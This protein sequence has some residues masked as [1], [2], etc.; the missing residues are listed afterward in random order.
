MTSNEKECGGI[1][2]EKEW[3]RS[4]PKCNNEIVYSNQYRLAYAIRDKTWCH[5]CWRF[6]RKNSTISNF[7]KDCPKCGDKVYLKTKYSLQR[8][9]ETNAVCHSCADRGN[10]GRLQSKEEKERRAIK[11]RGQKRSIEIRKRISNSKRGKRNPRFNDHSFK[12]IEHRR[13]IR[14]GC[15]KT[16]QTRLKLVGKIVSPAFNPDACNAIDEYG[17]RHEYAFQHALNGGEYYIEELGY[18]VDGYDKQKNVVVEFYEREH[19]RS[20]RKIKD[21]R[22]QIEIIDFLK[23]KFI[24]IH[25]NKEIERVH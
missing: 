10:N 21:R 6:K 24:I 19:N 11:L 18:W 8:S 4:C 17:R 3:K 22:R 1:G 13:K 7:S 2:Q 16:L 23:C 14:L 20:A 12:S 9:L 15:I 25:E 5:K